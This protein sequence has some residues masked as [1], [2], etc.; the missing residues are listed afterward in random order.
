MKELKRLL[1]ATGYSLQGIKY[2]WAREKN[3]RLLLGATVLISVMGYILPSI[4]QQ[5]MA[6][7]LLAMALVTVAETLNTAI[8]KTLDYASTGNYHPLIKI[9]KDV[10]SAAVFIAILFGLAILCLSLITP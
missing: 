9:A 5:E 7:L 8:E 10:A 4:S 1:R 2:L 3:F 6:L